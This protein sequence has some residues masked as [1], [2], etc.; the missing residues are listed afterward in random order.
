MKSLFFAAIFNLGFFIAY[1]GKSYAFYAKIDT[2][3]QG[4]K[5]TSYLTKCDKKPFRSKIALKFQSNS[6]D[7]SKNMDENKKSIWESLLKFIPG[8]SRAKL[9]KTYSTPAEDFGNRYHIR[10]MEPEKRF[11]RHVITRL[12]RYFPDLSWQTAEDIFETAASEGKALIRV[13]SSLVSY[14]L[15][16]SL[17]IIE[18][19]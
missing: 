2:P 1:V 10:L 17:F 13:V 6:D 18:L 15:C 7:R 16:M 14:R 11:K 3:V 5:R 4:Q 19:V 9:E 12:I 8:V